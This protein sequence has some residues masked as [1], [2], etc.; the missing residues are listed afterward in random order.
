MFLHISK[1]FNLGKDHLGKDPGPL[2]QA[3]KKFNLEK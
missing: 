3:K 2:T 1:E